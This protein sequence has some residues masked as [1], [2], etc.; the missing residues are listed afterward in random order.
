MIPEGVALCLSALDD[1]ETSVW[2]AALG[3]LVGLGASQAGGL[4]LTLLEQAD[5]SRR[6]ETIQ[7]LGHLGT[8]GLPVLTMA[9]KQ[10]GVVVRQAAARSL[11]WIPGPASRTA[12]AA[13]LVDP[14]PWV[15][16]EAAR[17]F[18][19]H[20]D[21]ESLA[22]LEPALGDPHPAVRNFAREAYRRLREHNVP[23]PSFVRPLR[24][25][26]L[27]RIWNCCGTNPVWNSRRTS[28][29]IYRTEQWLTTSKGETA[30]PGPRW[31][32]DRRRRSLG[33]GVYVG[34]GTPEEAPFLQM[35]ATQD[36]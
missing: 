5:V 28:G 19:R 8:A 9:M 6:E 18:I 20:P 30:G 17:A 35:F 36:V 12:L 11:G 4:V 33:P 27:F 23:S 14:E 32:F 34:P 13:A 16:Q 22:V 2:Q 31:R 29:V 1:P 3:G 15:R 21:P 24:P 25:C 10:G 7:V 26:R